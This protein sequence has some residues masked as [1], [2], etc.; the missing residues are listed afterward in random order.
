M[1]LI[2]GISTRESAFIAS[3][4][5]LSWDGTIRDDD[6]VKI[7]FF[8]LPDARLQYAYTGIAQWTVGDL[9]FATVGW[10]SGRIHDCMQTSPELERFLE[11]LQKRANEDFSSDPVLKSLRPEDKRLSVLFLGYVYSSSGNSFSVRATLSNFEDGA[12]GRRFPAAQDR[13]FLQIS[14]EFAIRVTPSLLLG[15]TNAVPQNRKLELDRMIAESK[16]LTALQ[17]K[18]Q[19]I[20]EE[21]S[22]NSLAKNSVG[23]NMMFSELSSNRERPPHTYNRSAT[24]GDRIHLGGMITSEFAIPKIELVLTESF[25][26][27]PSPNTRCPCGSGKKY[28]RC[29]GRGV[30]RR[31]FERT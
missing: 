19:Q 27:K 25:P 9:S 6:S 18:A 31:A 4:M 20:I 7:G 14:H 15:T 13:F 22:D 2:I 10:L 5:R 3:D 30:A 23:K 8:E 12:T 28:K 16:P 17:G 24:G 29:H 1:T 21:A 26:G 11:E